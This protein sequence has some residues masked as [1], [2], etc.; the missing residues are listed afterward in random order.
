MLSQLE[1]LNAA[2]ETTPAL[3]YLP[4]MQTQ[5]SMMIALARIG[6]VPSGR[7]SPNAIDQL[8]ASGV[9]FTVYDVDRALKEKT[10]L[11]VQQKLQFKIALDRAGLLK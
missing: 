3:R 2:T 6:L 11:T 10:T 1:F 8:N 9:K 4:P 7:T 5:E